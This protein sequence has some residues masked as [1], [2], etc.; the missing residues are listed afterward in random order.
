V[1]DFTRHQRKIVDRY[2][3]HLD[4]IMLTKLAEL[5]SELY[6]ADTDQK[7]DRLWGRVEKAIAKLKIN[8]TTA[9][10]I[11][12]QKSTELLAKHLTDWQ[13]SARS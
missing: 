7:R 13:A 2:Y 4:G 11:M 5:V 6:L 10:H 9:S 12:E 1:A 8:P 3:E